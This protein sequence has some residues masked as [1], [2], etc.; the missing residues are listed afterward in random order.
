MRWFGHIERKKS[1]E[2]V[3]KVYVSEIERSRR[4]ERPIVRWK[5]GMKEYVYERVADSVVGGI[6][7]TR[8]EC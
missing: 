5:D 4:R 3:K 2:F 7:L 8:R 1:E 6:E